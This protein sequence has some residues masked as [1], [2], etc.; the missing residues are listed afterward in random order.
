MK[1][2]FFVVL[3]S[4]LVINVGIV[5]IALFNKEVKASSDTTALKGINVI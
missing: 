4:L 3:K 2:I 5:F 1:K